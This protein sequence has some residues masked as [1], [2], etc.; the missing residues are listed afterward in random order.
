MWWK[1]RGEKTRVHTTTLS[2]WL[3]GVLLFMEDARTSISNSSTYSCFYI[4]SYIMHMCTHIKKNIYMEEPLIR[5][6]YSY[7]LRN[8]RGIEK[9]MK[10]G[11]FL[12]HGTRRKPPE[13]VAHCTSISPPAMGN[14]CLDQRKESAL[15][16]LVLIADTWPELKVKLNVI[17]YA[18]PPPR[19]FFTRN[20]HKS[21]SLALFFSHYFS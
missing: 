20:T 16:T 10:K 19:T 2:G 15:F 14:C 3:S 6:F 18:F 8:G 21:P 13:S 5:T 11:S 9:G 12:A 17:Y 4:C 1:Y 7:F